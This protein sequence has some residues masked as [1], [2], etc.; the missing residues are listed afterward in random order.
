MDS[1]TRSNSLQ[2]VG[3]RHF[4][5]RGACQGTWAEGPHIYKK[6]GWYYLLIAEGGTSFNHA[7][8]IAASKNITGP[9]DAN[10]RNPILSSRH[11]SYDYWIN[12]TGHAD[13]VELPNGEWIMVC[14]GIRNEEN[15][16][17]TWA[18]KPYSS[19]SLGK[20]TLLV[21]RNKI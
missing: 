19:C 15:R 5:W 12:S 8:M 9:Y 6:D 10:D 18:E 3:E 21:E 17:L 13:M 16:V 11:L 1:R 7:V 20:R 4:L 2:L 14:L